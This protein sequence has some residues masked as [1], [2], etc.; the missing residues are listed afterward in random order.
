MTTTSRLTEPRRRILARLENLLNLL[1]CF[2]A[3]ARAISTKGGIFLFLPISAQTKQ[4]VKVAPQLGLAFLFLGKAVDASIAQ[5][6]SVG[7]TR[8]DST[9]ALR[10]LD[11]ELHFDRNKK[12]RFF[13]RS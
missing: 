9:I 8:G 4:L 3:S 5:F 13:S 6:T 7:D 12:K 1:C 11:R 2:L 10:A